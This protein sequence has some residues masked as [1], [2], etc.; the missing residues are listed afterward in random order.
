MSAKLLRNLRGPL[1]A[2]YDARLNPGDLPFFNQDGLHTYLAVWSGHSGDS[3]PL[4]VE[5]GGC[6]LLLCLPHSVDFLSSYRQLNGRLS[7]AV[8]K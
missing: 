1:R 8:N 3:V 7:V 4:Q 5:S 6:S 2:Q